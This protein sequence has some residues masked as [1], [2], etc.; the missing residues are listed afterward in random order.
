MSGLTYMQGTIQHLSI[1]DA[2]AAPV[3]DR[4][5]IASSV[6]ADTGQSSCIAAV[7]CWCAC[8]PAARHRVVTDHRG[9]ALPHHPHGAPRGAPR[10]RLAV[11]AGK[12]SLENYPATPRGLQTQRLDHGRLHRP[13]SLVSSR[14]GWGSCGAGYSRQSD[15]NS[16]RAMAVTKASG[17]SSRSSE[18]A[19]RAPPGDGKWPRPVG[20]RRFSNIEARAVSNEARPPHPTRIVVTWVRTGFLAVRSETQ[21]TAAGGGREGRKSCPGPPPPGGSPPRRGTCCTGRVSRGRWRGSRP[22]EQ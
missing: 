2:S 6:D 5:P 19:P 12:W 15:G 7:R 18:Y 4:G 17:K 3:R 20:F 21:P 22:I 13:Q 16:L 10:T 1:A 11:N 14:S 9:V 8:R